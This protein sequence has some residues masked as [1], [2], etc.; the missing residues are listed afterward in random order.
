M[1]D[2]EE[3]ANDMALKI[4]NMYDE[5]QKRD[6]Q[7]ILND[8]YNIVD[9]KGYEDPRNMAKNFELG[10]NGESNNQI[11]YGEGIACKRLIDGKF[12]D[13]NLLEIDDDKV[14]ESFDIETSV[15]RDRYREM[16]VRKNDSASKKLD[17]VIKRAI[18][19]VKEMTSIKIFKILIF[20]WIVSMAI[21]STFQLIFSNQF[22]SNTEN[23]IDIMLEA[24]KQLGY[25]SKINSEILDISFLKEG[26]FHSGNIVNNTV[27]CDLV[28]S[29]LNNSVGLVLQN[30]KT[31]VQ[32]EYLS[33]I[34]AQNDQFKYY[35]SLAISQGRTDSYFE[36]TYDHHIQMLTSNV[37]NIT[38]NSDCSLDKSRDFNTFRFNY[39]RELKP[40]ITSYSEQIYK[41]LVSETS[42]LLRT[43]AWMFILLLAETTSSL[44]FVVY[45]IWLKNR[46]LRK[47]QEILFL[48]LDI[49]RNEVTGIFKKCDSFLN[50]F[51]GFSMDKEAEHKLLLDSSDEEDSFEKE[52]NGYIQV[53]AADKESTDEFER[54]MA[55]HRPDQ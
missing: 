45:F 10:T 38:K 27:S 44:L 9:K 55:S 6:L 15:F 20:I 21:M 7:D 31:L 43:Q 25:F 54:K 8:A 3:T 29:S 34:G 24:N 28:I 39:F 49:P 18:S 35:D 12:Y 41:F 47:K 53:Q 52:M 51:N 32:K 5:F 50:Y 16:A 26:Y 30:S 37:I 17:K 11:D 42:S 1:N 36:I 46:V 40:R 13:V 48:F 2:V 19:N 4:K 33:K 14:D 22:F 23:L